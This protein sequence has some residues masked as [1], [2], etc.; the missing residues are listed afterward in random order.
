M[1]SIQFQFKKFLIISIKNLRPLGSVAIRLTQ[2]TGKSRYPIHPKHLV[3][4]SPPW[5]LKYLSGRDIVLDLGCGNGQNTLKAAK[6]VKKMIGVDK[7][8]LDIFV[9]AQL[10]KEMALVNIKFKHGDLEKKLDF[11]K[12]IFDKVLFL[13]CLEHINNETRSLQEVNR[14]LK[15]NGLLL[16]SLPN[17]QTSWKKTQRQYG[18]NSFTDADHKR[19]YSKEEAVNLCKRHGFK[20]LNISEITYDSPFAPVFDLFGGF[21]LSLY[22]R[23]INYK[24]NMALKKPQDSTGFRIVAQ[25]IRSI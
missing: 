6:M 11:G 20:I 10:A 23:F 24:Y 8:H 15:T 7:N 9:A 22:K 21:S 2:L 5:Y 12:Q 25:K 17:S 13:D 3:E 18:I 1:N 14:V 4:I 16:L 19:E